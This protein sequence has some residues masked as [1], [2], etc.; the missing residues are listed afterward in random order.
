MAFFNHLAKSRARA[1]S[2]SLKLTREVNPFAVQVIKEIG[3]DISNSNQKPKQLA[4]YLLLLVKFDYIIT[5]GCINACLV[6]SKEKTIKWN[7]QDLKGVE[8]LE[9]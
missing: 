3:I 4:L 2:A 6:T 5:T 7:I 9:S 8:N 1:S